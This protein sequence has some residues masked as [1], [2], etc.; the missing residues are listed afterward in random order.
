MYST[1]ERI[2]DDALRDVRDKRLLLEEYDRWLIDQVRPYLGRRLLEVGCG[3]GNVLRLIEGSVQEIV[4]IDVD[5]ESID[6]VWQRFGG[7]PAFR[8]LKGDICDVE[9]VEAVRTG[10]D[11]VLS[12]NV[13][14]HIE[15]D[16][17]ALSHMKR[18]LVP[19]GYLIA[20]APAHT[21]L[22]NRMDRS[23]GHHRRYTKTD[24]STKLER[25]GCRVEMLRYINWLGAIGWLLR[26]VSSGKADMP[27]GQ[28]K[29]M[30]ALIPALRRLEAQVEPPFGISLLAVAR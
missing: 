1:D 29:L 12:V 13:L 8:A 3:W 6:R 30:N 16:L 5:E 7:H 20:I 26:G 19:G 21:F 24:L 23:I 15:D 4:A 10:F 17:L 25:I 11:T 22:Y 27:A 14:E 18:V 2:V 28:L 9:T